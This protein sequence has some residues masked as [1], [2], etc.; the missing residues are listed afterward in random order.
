M[1]YLKGSNE[2]AIRNVFKSAVV[3]ISWITSNG[4]NEE[5]VLKLND[6]IQFK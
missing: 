3:K 2:Q 5:K 6:F 1:F 4:S